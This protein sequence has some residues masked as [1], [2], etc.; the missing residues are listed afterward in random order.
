MNFKDFDAVIDARTPA[1]YALD[2]IPGAVSAPVLDDAQRVEVGTLYKQVSPSRRRSSARRWSHRTWRG[3]SR[4]FSAGKIR[5]EAAGLLLARRQ[6]LGRD[7]A[8]PARDRLGRASTLEG[9]YRAYRRWVVEQLATV[10][11]KLRLHRG[12]RSHG[13]RQEPPPRRARARGRAGARSRGARRASRLGARRPAGEPQP[14]QKWFESQLLAELERSTASAAGLRRG[15]IEEDRRDPGT[16]SA[17]GAHA[18]LTLHASSRPT[19]R[20]ASRCSSTNT[21]TSSPT[22]RRSRRSSTAWRTAWPRGSP[23]GKRSPR[24]A[25]G[26][27]SSRGSS[28]STTTRV[29]ALRRRSNFPQLAEAPTVRITR[30]YARLRRRRE[31]WGQSNFSGSG[32]GRRS[33]EGGNPV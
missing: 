33:R 32:F 10:P 22:A 23:S 21:A 18:R 4:R 29:R 20:R 2:H 30:R 12:P 26:A 8:H 9:G 14:T 1:E 3:I 31:K 16:R 17:D 27:S 6:A 13:Q 11:P 25:T 7:G 15:R 24:R 28:P 19:S 5:L